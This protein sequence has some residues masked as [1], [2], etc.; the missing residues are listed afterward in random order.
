ML[1]FRKGS[2]KEVKEKA[3]LEASCGPDKIGCSFLL[4]SPKTS[5]LLFL[6]FTQSTDSRTLTLVSTS[7]TRFTLFITPAEL[8]LR[9][10]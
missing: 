10:V 3:V 7:E 2:G 5:W 4:G 1:F 6:S 9:S 8:I